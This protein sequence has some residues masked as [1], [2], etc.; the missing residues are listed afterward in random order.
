M[1]VKGLKDGNLGLPL[2]TQ[3]QLGVGLREITP[4][5]IGGGN[6][7]VFERNT[8]TLNIQISLVFGF[9]RLTLRSHCNEFC[10]KFF[11]M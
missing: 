11:L 1:A 4:F 5:V 8:L 9:I 10:Y 3:T 7:N 2:G 6:V